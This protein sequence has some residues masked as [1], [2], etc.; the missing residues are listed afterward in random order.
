MPE[1]RFENR[2]SDKTYIR[3]L[4]AAA[5]LYR[6]KG[7]TAVSMRTIAKAAHIKAGSIYYHFESKDDIV[8]I[9]LNLG[10]KVVHDEVN[11]IV[12]N[13]PDDA[14]ASEIVRAG[15]RGHLHALLEYRNY[16]SANVRIYGQVPAAIQESNLSARRKYEKFW[17]N[18]L[19]DL[20]ESGELRAQIDIASFRLLIIGAL[21]ATLEWFDQEKGDC[22]VLA[23]NYADLLLNG[24][25]TDQ[26]AGT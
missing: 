20:Q 18:L 13:L 8:S 14:T 25:L 12:T 3:I 9:I 22:S 1:H 4:D 26:E 2:N 15:I 5:R 17:D 11:R 23:D 24:I 10:I 21:N 6:E 16:T 19:T 7:Y